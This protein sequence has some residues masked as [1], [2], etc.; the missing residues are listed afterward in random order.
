MTNDLTVTREEMP[1]PSGRTKVDAADSD[2]PVLLP[3]VQQVAA[4]ATDRFS[5]LSGP[6]RAVVSVG[7]VAFLCFFVREQLINNQEQFAHWIREERQLQEHLRLRGIEHGDKTG[8][9]LADAIREQ[10]REQK[11]YH[12]EMMFLFRELKASGKMPLP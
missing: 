10:T 11:T 7:I 12:Q 3:T 5:G 9:Q 4:E 8:K 6:W 1:V 2:L